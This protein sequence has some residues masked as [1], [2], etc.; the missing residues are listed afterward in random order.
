MNI[1]FINIVQVIMIYISALYT[2]ITN[3]Y[4]YI[5]VRKQYF[6]YRIVVINILIKIVIKPFSYWNRYPQHPLAYIL[7]ITCYLY[8]DLSFRQCLCGHILWYYLTSW[9]KDVKSCD[10]SILMGML[11]NYYWCRGTK[12]IVIYLNLF[13]RMY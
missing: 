2:Y 11:V 3:L 10:L 5:T 13:S 12:D 1:A 8:E 9:V 6:D 7:V 4:T